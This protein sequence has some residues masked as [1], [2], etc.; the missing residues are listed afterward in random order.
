LQSGPT[1][2]ITTRI[3]EMNAT[4]DENKCCDIVET[5]RM[6]TII[7]AKGFGNTLEY[8]TFF[9]DGQCMFRY[10]PHF[11]VK[12]LPLQSIDF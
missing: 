3:L 11:F 12:E 7:K 2:I 1:P 5:C 4:L 9:Y 6:C 8:V 10:D